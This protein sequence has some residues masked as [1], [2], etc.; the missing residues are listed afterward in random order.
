[1]LGNHNDIEK[2]IWGAAD[3]FDFAE[4]LTELNGVIPEEIDP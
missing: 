4:R 2:R 3:Y 1:M